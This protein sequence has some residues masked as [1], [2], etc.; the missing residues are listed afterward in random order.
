MT[1]NERKMLEDAVV[2]FPDQTSQSDVIATNGDRIRSMSDGDLAEW[3]TLV[4]CLAR[5]K[6]L[7]NSPTSTE[8]R[9]Y[10]LEWLKEG[11]G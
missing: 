2:L 11:N 4:E 5:S 10:W 8:I 7:E 6:G 9:A 1:N 3:L